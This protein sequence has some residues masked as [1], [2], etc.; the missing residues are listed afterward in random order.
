MTS[1]VVT[2]SDCVTPNEHHPE[3]AY[4]M[5]GTEERNAYD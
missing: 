2:G 3:W 5:I 4:A 1:G